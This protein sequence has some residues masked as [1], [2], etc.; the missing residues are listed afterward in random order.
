M[1]DRIEYRIESNRIE[2]RIEQN[3]IIEQ[4]TGIAFYKNNVCKI[5]QN[6]IEQNRIEQNTEQNIEQNCMIEQKIGIAL[7][8]LYVHY[9]IKQELK[10]YRFI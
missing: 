8:D 2:N 9:K 5:E 4:K 3:C 6:R 7:L 10:F 1:Q